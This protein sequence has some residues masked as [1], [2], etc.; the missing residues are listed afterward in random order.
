MTRRDITLPVTEAEALAFILLFA[1][2]EFVRLLTPF[3]RPQGEPT[4]MQANVLLNRRPDPDYPEQEG[5]CEAY[6]TVYPATA[7]GTQ[8]NGEEEEFYPDLLPGIAGE[9]S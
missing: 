3:T 2:D 5:E 1:G 6:Y 9:W 7:K 8:V 4:W